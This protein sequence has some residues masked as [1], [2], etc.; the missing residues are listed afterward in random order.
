[1]RLGRKRELPSSPHQQNAQ[2]IINRLTCRALRISRL[3]QEYYEHTRM[4]GRESIY[5]SSDVGRLARIGTPPP[6]P[7]HHITR[8]R[9]CDVCMAGEC[10][11]HKKTKACLLRRALSSIALCSHQQHCFS[12]T[13]AP[14][15]A[16]LFSLSAVSRLLH[17][18]D[19]STDDLANKKTPNNRG[20][21]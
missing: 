18:Y 1:M 10:R 7:L 12:R 20:F 3:R 4:C 19:Y 16:L 14:S 6:F 15:I 8:L 11:R 21:A 17:D 13:A 5:F 2:A 9:R